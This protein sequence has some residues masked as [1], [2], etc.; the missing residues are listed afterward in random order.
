M[1]GCRHRLSKPFS[2]SPGEFSRHDRSVHRSATSYPGTEFRLRS[3]LS[4]GHTLVRIRGRLIEEMDRR[5]NVA[6]N[7]ALN[8]DIVH[9]YSNAKRGWSTLN[10]KG[11]TR[12]LAQLMLDARLDNIW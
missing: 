6:R 12:V 8:I 10:G 1:T 7:A 5:Q 9:Q 3:G 4:V 11:L 2:Y